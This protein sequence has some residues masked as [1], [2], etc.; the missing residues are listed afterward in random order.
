M[1]SAGF[2]DPG[3]QVQKPPV[4][5]AELLVNL[6]AEALDLFIQHAESFGDHLDL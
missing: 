5:F 2:G 4:N 1:D 3:V 6:L